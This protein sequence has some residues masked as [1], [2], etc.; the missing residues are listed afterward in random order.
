MWAGDDVYT[1]GY[2]LVGDNSDSYDPKAV[3]G[4]AT[5]AADGTLTIAAN[6]VE[7]SMMADNSVNS[8]EIAAGAVD[9]AHVASGAWDFGT[10]VEADTLTEGGNAVWNDADTDV[11]DDT[12][13][14]WAR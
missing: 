6:A 13:L 5:L 3:G 7:N 8:A 10:S 11:V 1:G 12:H 2:I 9:P 14:N 4:D